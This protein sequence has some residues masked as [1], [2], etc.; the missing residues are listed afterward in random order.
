[1]HSVW[2]A[3]GWTPGACRRG[4][5]NAPTIA[6]RPERSA[7][8]RQPLTRLPWPTPTTYR[9]VL[10]VQAARMGGMRETAAAPA[11]GTRE[12]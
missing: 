5:S 8:P 10:R 7:L 4:D 2:I 12:A 11:G 9:K 6:T 1:M 3:K